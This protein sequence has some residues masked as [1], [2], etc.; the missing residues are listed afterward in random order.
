MLEEEEIEVLDTTEEVTGEAVSEEIAEATGVA[1]E[2]AEAADV[3][4]LLRPISGNTDITTKGT[5][6]IRTFNRSKGIRANKDST[7]VI[8]LNLDKSI[9]INLNI[10]SMK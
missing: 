5:R 3:D 8:N 1:A 10:S 4:T 7:K 6:G 2:E 9:Q